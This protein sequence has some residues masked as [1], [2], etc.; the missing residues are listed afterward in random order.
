MDPTSRV[1]FGHSALQVTR[2]GVGTVPIAGLYEEKVGEMA[3]KKSKEIM[4]Q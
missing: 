2:L 4:E 1:P 3:D